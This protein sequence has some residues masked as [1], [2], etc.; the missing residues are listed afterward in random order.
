MYKTHNLKSLQTLLILLFFAAVSNAQ[1]EKAIFQTS[2]LH[3]NFQPTQGEAI[4][5]NLK[6]DDAI[7]F[8]APVVVPQPVADG[9]SWTAWVDT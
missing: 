7:H 4:I 3:V 1:T 8:D 5:Q 6:Q 2:S 9:I